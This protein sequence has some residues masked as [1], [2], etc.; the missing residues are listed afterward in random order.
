M[1]DK[2]LMLWGLISD[3]PKFGLAKEITATDLLSTIK[4]PQNGIL[5]DWKQWTLYDSHC[6]IRVWKSEEEYTRDNLYQFLLD[7]YD[8]IPNMTITGIMSNIGK[9]SPVLTLRFEGYAA[10]EDGSRFHYRVS[11][12]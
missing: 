5:Y 10:I 2:E 8:E 6:A 4:T 7:H 1:T 3:I 11:F 9:I 12:I